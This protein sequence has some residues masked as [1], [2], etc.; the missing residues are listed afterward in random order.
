MARIIQ[1]LDGGLGNQMFQY[2]NCYA[3]A[4]DNNMGLSIYSLY[5]DLIPGSRENGLSFFCIPEQFNKNVPFSVLLSGTKCVINRIINIFFKTKLNCSICV[6]NSLIST[7]EETEMAYQPIDV[8]AKKEFY[9]L[10]GFWQSSLY[11]SNYRS[12]ILKLFTLKEQYLQKVLERKEYQ[13]IVND[14]LSVA[15]HV[16]HG[17]FQKIGWV[18]DPEYY[19]S[20]KAIM[21]QRLGKPHFYVFSDD[22]SWCRGFFCDAQDV[23]FVES[24]S[25]AF[26]YEDMFLMSKCKHNIIANSTYSWWGAYL[27]CNPNQIVIAPNQIKKYTNADILTGLSWEII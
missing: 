27:N 2:A 17:D 3:V 20:A 7:I 25:T 18:I 13:Q 4:N 16:R 12:E 14:D 22:I 23:T 26:S 1:C 24:D 5:N 8:S 9:L 21:T 11:F 19:I 6:N 15:I 10:K